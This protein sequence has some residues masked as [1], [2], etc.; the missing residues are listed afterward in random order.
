M[1][2]VLAMV[3]AG[4]RGKRMDIMCYGRPKPALPF[5][6]R[7]RVIDFSL[8]NCIHSQIRDAA[9]LI[10]YQRSQLA[11]YLSNWYS[12]NAGLREAAILE[13]RTGSYRG[14]ADAV[15]QN[16]DYVDRQG[17]DTVLILAGDHIYKMDYRKLVAYHQQVGADVTVGV[18]PVPI[19][20]AHRFGTVITDGGGRITE[21]VEKS[22]MPK[23]NLASMGIY[24]FRRD[25]LE[26]R[27][28]ED[29][30]R[31]DSPHDFGYAI[32]PGM[33]GRD[34]V[35]AYK[36]NGYWQDIGTVEAYYAASMELVRQKPSFSLDGNWPVLAQDKSVPPARKSGQGTIINS[37][38]S[39]G[40]TVKGRVENSILGPGVWV[41]EQA[42]VKDSVLMDNAFVGYHSVVDHCILDEGVSIG[43]FSYIGL[44]TSL[45]P[46]D[47]GVTVLGKGVT[48][49]NRTAI[50]RNCR[51]SPHVNVADLA[52]SAVPPGTVVSPQSMARSTATRERV[53]A[54][55]RTGER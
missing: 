54:S 21:F 37:I 1:G 38:T 30:R 29:A 44:G 24:V 15:Y 20:Q 52:T 11:N 53:A 31:P 36:F 9:V 7:F 40:C 28:N 5:A 4:G 17:A 34:R 12:A 43:R 14:T 23:S 46:E 32:L 39:S 35:S 16:L 47:P 19:D 55:G 49:P 8:S 41:D 13:P 33:V 51:I 27:L 3:L 42:V 50:G 10:D 48:V 45:L 6:G 2:R 18:V 22:S 25:T 26:R